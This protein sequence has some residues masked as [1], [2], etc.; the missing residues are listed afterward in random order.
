MKHLVWKDVALGVG[1]FLLLGGCSDANG[2]ADA[3]SDADT[4]VDVDAI[5]DD[6]TAADRSNGTVEFTFQPK[7]GQVFGLTFAIWMENDAGEYMGTMSIIDFIGREGGGNHGVQVSAGEDGFTFGGD[8]PSA[9]PIWAHRRNVVDTTYGNESLYPP[10]S[11]SPT[12]PDDIDAV[13]SA[14]PT[15]GVTQITTFNLSDVPYGSYNFFMEVNVSIDTNESYS[16]FRGQPSV[17]W[18]VSVTIGDSPDSAFVLDYAGFGSEDG[19]DGEVRPV[20]STITTAATLLNDIG[21]YR[22]KVDYAP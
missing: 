12:Y 2:E 14:T 4:D 18:T 11:S 13:T 19:S 9:L 3:D 16:S 20:D 22:F 6:T 8:R 15:G 1:F 21:G 7:A 5:S 10:P 17:L